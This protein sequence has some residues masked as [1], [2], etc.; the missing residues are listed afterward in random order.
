MHAIFFP[1]AV[2]VE[3]GFHPQLLLDPARGI[4]EPVDDLR[5][6]VLEHWSGFRRCLRVSR[7]CRMCEIGN[8]REHK[9][10]LGVGRSKW[11]GHGGG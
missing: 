9:N 2:A 1:I 7:R 10:A 5:L 3:V 11:L 8:K 4:F 6:T